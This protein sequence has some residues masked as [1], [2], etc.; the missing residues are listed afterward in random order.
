MCLTIES[1]ASDTPDIP[2]QA[3]P[4]MTPIRSSA[5]AI[6]FALCFGCNDTTPRSMTQPSSVPGSST[7]QPPAPIVVPPLTGAALTYAFSQQLSYPVRPYTVDSKYVLY[8][9]GA[10]TLQYPGGQYVGAYDRDN[11]TVFFRFSA[12]AGQWVATATLRGD[13]LQVQYNLDMEMSDFENA[14][15]RLK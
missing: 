14:A 4:D 1:G 10:F 11:D 7:V 3:G 15:Y 13:S 12:N 9:N 5:L 6:A 8:E 2:G